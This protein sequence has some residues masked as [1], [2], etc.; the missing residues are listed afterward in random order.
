MLRVLIIEPYYGGSHSAFI[1]GLMRRLPFEFLLMRMPARKWK[2]R[3]RLAAPMMADELHR[4][5]AR[6]DRILCSTFLD[7]AAFRGLAP[8]WA[9]ETPLLTYYHEN[10]FAYPVQVNNERD[11]H[12]ALT[13]IT[14]A[15]ASDSL[16]FNTSY[17]MESFITGALDLMRHAP[18]MGIDDLDARIRERSRVIAPAMDFSAIDYALA[19]PTSRDSAPPLICWNHRWE[20]DKGPDAFFEAMY[21][22]DKSGEDFSLAVMGQAFDRRPDVFDEARGRLAHRAIQFGY[23]STREDYARMLVRSDVCVSTALHEFFGI[24][25]M[26]AVRAGCRPVAPR[27]LSYP[28]LLPEGFLYDSDAGLLQA[29]RDAM[30][31]GRL[32]ADE[33]RAITEPY[34]WDTLGG[35]YEDWMASA[36]TR[37]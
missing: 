21:A 14:T 23:A 8:R 33:G 36:I 24:S 16:A 27:R 4:S 22:L 7:V 31:S 12:F 25:M 20:H 18:D 5:G 15:L 1:E 30:R 11:M 6:F 10:Q 37:P 2:W 35:A 13:N 3:M 28:E 17:N 9:R 32:G 29:I 19:R 34:S 26:E